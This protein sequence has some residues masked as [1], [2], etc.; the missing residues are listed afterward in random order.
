MSG[1]SV[2]E[3]RI[4][5]VN[6][7]QKEFDRLQRD[8]KRV[9]GEG[10]KATT[11]WDRFGKAGKTASDDVSKAMAGASGRAGML[12]NALSALGPVGIAA[13]AAIGGIA[14]A[15]GAGT[16]SMADWEKRLGRTE[17]LIKAT[18]NAAGLTAGELDNLARERDL[19][20]LGD[21]NQIMDAINV[22]QTFKSVTGDTFRES[23]ALAQDMSAVTGQS[24]TGSVTMLGKALEDP[25]AGLTAMRR[26]G[27]SL[28]ETEQE[29][30]RAMV[31]LNDVAGAQAKI[32]EVLRGQFEGAAEAEAQGLAGALDT[33]SYSWRDLMESMSNTSAASD[34]VGGLTDLI[35]SLTYAV[36]DLSDNFTLDEQANQLEQAIAAQQ[37]S[38]QVMRD[39][40]VALPVLDAWIGKSANL[41]AA[42]A[43]LVQLEN[44]LRRVK[45]L[46]EGSDMVDTFVIHD[47]G[48]K[49]ATGRARDYKVL[50][51]AEAERARIAA[52]KAAAERAKKEAEAKRKQ[53]ERD[54]ETAARKAEADEK[55]RIQRM[56][57]YREQLDEARLGKEY[58]ERQ[59][60][61]AHARQMVADGMSQTDA[62]FWK[63]KQFEEMSKTVKEEVGEWQHAFGDFGDDAQTIF[64][65]M[66]R[67]L[68]GVFTTGNRYL[69]RFM[70]RLMDMYLMQPFENLIFNSGS[71]GG[72]FD[73]FGSIGSVF[74]SIFHEGGVVGGPAPARLVPADLFAGAPRYHSGG[75]VG[76]GE[77]PIIARDGEI[78]LNAAQQNAL[79]GRLGGQVLVE[80]PVTVINGSNER[81]TTRR[82]PGPMGGVKQLKIFIG[83]VTDENIRSSRHDAALSE[84]RRRRP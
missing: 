68:A 45:A 80:I 84:A 26:V 5:A 14:T 71:S 33:L 31:E 74:S 65:E 6:E 23:I 55:A 3:T 4:R 46:Q 42:Q 41:D 48:K 50:E 13:G 47:K 30:V 54:A 25:I 27:V 75:G 10:Q 12:G 53:E 52:E 61:E 76:P 32:M 16:M 82:E 69:D 58:V 57:K 37:R 73:L 77:R 8:L 1:G 51:D 21:R 83:D 49:A 78:I 70:Q 20:T 2:V 35:R 9:Q 29:V 64:R 56:A 24:L 17:A 39:E 40:A 66:G 62:D 79:A 36:K 60:I 63:Q 11:V 43:A 7:S 28:T 44:Q 34:A 19:A 67:D 18:G 81:V 38:I 59:R 22:M 15:I 72:G